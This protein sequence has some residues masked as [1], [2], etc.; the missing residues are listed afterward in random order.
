MGGKISA[1]DQQCTHFRFEMK[2]RT[3]CFIKTLG[4]E[5]CRG[6]NHH[7]RPCIKSQ[8]EIKEEKKKTFVTG[9][10]SKHKIFASSEVFKKHFA[11]C[12]KREIRF[13]SALTLK[14]C[15]LGLSWWSSG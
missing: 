5:H 13:I 4:R 10:H 9:K 6:Q 12:L 14:C 15:E 7:S 2:V 8:E 11:K 1:K 3:S